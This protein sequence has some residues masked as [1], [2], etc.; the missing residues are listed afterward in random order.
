MYCVV[1]PVVQTNVNSLTIRPEY[2]SE[3]PFIQEVA[4]FVYRRAI[5]SLDRS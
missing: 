1:N 4:V 5:F 2:L 3:Y